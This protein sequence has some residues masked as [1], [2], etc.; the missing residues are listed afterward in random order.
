MSFAFPI[1]DAHFWI[2]RDSEIIDDEYPKKD[3][4]IK[5]IWKCNDTKCYL[6][7]SDEIQEAVINHHKKI[8]MKKLRVKDWEDALDILT[9][10]FEI[11]KYEPMYGCC[12][13]NVMYELTRNRN[14]TIKFG[15]MGFE[16]KN[17]D[18]VHWEFG[19]ENWT[20][21]D[22]GKGTAFCKIANKK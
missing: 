16:K 14:G 17:G 19:G 1:I 5:Q 20:I 6:E 12:F 10:I 22:F 18:G 9:E 21:K 15:S 3:A 7:A 13:L 2:E 8:V 4:I 11:N